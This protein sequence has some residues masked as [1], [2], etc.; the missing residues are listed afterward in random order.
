MKIFINI[1]FISILIF[2]ISK[3][4]YSDIL[5]SKD[6]IPIDDKLGLLE[7]NSSIQ[8]NKNIIVIS[9]TMKKIF[10]IIEN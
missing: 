8:I 6:L 2:F 10:L 7:L 5:E 3:L 1:I 9:I 4:S